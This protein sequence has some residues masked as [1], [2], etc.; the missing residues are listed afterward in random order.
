MNSRLSDVPVVVLTDANSG[1]QKCI[2]VAHVLTFKPSG[3][4]TLITFVNGDTLVVREHFGDVVNTLLPDRHD[5]TEHRQPEIEMVGQVTI[6]QGRTFADS[7]IERARESEVP[8]E[9][10]SAARVMR[11]PD[12]NTA[13]QA[14]SDAILDDI[15]GRFW[16]EVRE[17]VAEAFVEAA[18]RVRRE[19]AGW[20]GTAV[21][22]RDTLKNE[23]K[24][25]VVDR[26]T[27]EHGL[28]F[29]QGWY[30]G[31]MTDACDDTEIMTW[32]GGDLEQTE[33]ELRFHDL[34]DEICANVFAL[35]K[36]QIAEAFVRAA[37]EVLDRERGK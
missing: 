27:I 14:R 25:E 15:L 8:D 13:A 2:N 1:E 32:P 11:W 9:A 18:N 34:T 19:R 17:P 31:D 6:E 16:T 10:F 22:G 20:S 21:T 26:V 28:A 29:A 4:W 23:A 3:N 36:R 24:I 5:A 12:D 37:N 35:T 33:A 30:N 7:F